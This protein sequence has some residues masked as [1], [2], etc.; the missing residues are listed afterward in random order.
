VAQY[1]KNSL[2]LA[3]T[4]AMGTG[5]M[6]GAGIFA[7]TGQVAELAGALF[8]LAFLL[9]AGVSGLSAYSYIVVSRKYPSAGGIAMI[10]SKAY[11]PSAVAAGAAMLMAFSM[12]I[13]ESLVART[14][15]TYTLQLFGLPPTSVWVPVLA[16][17]VILLGF[18]VNLAGN[19]AIGTISKVA[20]VLKVGGIV[21]F[22]A[23]ALWAAG[24]DFQAATGPDAA[25]SGPAG[26][27]AATALGILAYK[28][29]T[30]ITNSGDEV[31]DPHRN[32]G[33]AIII[34][35]LICAVVY[36]LV[37]FAVGSSLT[38]PQIVDARDYSLAEASRP[39]FGDAGV[40]F[41]V[42][43]AIIATVSG[44]LASFFAVSR[45]LAMLTDMQLIPHRHFGMPG[46][47]QQHTLV[48]TVVVAGALAVLFDL[49]RIAAVG[50]IFY[51]VMDVIVHWGVLRHLRTDVGA[52]PAILIAAIVADVVALGAFVI[53]RGTQDPVIIIGAIAAVTV[54][55]AFEALYLR[56]RNPDTEKPVGGN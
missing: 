5:V 25:G 8:P 26:V 38:I 28:G 16:L 27:L 44:L 17:G 3:A 35:L 13:N 23:A 21:A 46:G 2:S 49:S 47:I 14:F 41:T 31:R 22:A 24:F 6:V 19:E 7:L 4:V 30:T 15:G 54:I 39:T 9:A 10:L 36:L 42:V 55:F 20:A 52:R 56:H 45:M 33:R 51:L 29:F 12:V 11:G 32:V 48:Y 50:A 53:L 34:S 40:T 43:I 37:A 1:E 18:G